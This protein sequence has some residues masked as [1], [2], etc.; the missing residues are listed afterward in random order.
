MVDK[1]YLLNT[2]QMAQFVAA[3]FL[4]FDEL[5]PDEINRAACAEMETGVPRGRAGAPLSE[6][7]TDAAIG[8]VV[9]LPQIQGII[10]SLVGPGPL[11]DHHAVHTVDAHHEHGQIWHADAIIDTRLH[12]D[13]QLFY[14]A[15]DTPREMGGTMFLPGSIYRRISESDIARYQNFLGQMPMV[16]K[17]GTVAVAHHGIWHCAQPNLTGRK[18]YMF[19]LRLNPTVRQK[20]LWNTD[21]IDD[22]EI[23]GLLNANHRWYGNEVRLE[24]VN[25]IK[26]WRFLTGDENYDVSYWLSRLENAPENELRAA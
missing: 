6:L 25:R 16:C 24:V 26:L 11:Y 9:R 14:F 17:A 3:G 5:V 15:H 19:K 8:R 22:A 10:H 18:R 4:R 21:D 7:W 1:Q 12:F 23:P 2:K 13:I 20:K